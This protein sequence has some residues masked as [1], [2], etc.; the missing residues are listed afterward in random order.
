VAQVQELILNTQ[1]QEVC[2][3]IVLLD[4]GQGMLI[5][6]PS[7]SAALHPLQNIYLEISKL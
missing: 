1:R 4:V 7:H 2:A 3:E 5:Q 6:V